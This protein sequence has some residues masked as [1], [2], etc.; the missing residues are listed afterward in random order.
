VSRDFIDLPAPPGHNGISVN[1][2]HVMAILSMPED[3]QCLL[4]M[5]TDIRE[6]E[7]GNR[8]II[9]AA[10]RDRAAAALRRNHEVVAVNLDREDWE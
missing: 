4:V 9:V 3:N 10:P 2:D 8:N 5:T 6:D 7:A 1:P